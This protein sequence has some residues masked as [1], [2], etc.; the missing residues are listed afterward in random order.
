MANEFAPNGPAS[1]QREIAALEKRIAALR[2]RLGTVIDKRATVAA[3]FERAINELRGTR[4]ANSVAFAEVVLMVRRWKEG[5]GGY[6]K[7]E[8]TIMLRRLYSTYV[9]LLR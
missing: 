8:I 1:I 6:T 4:A 7:G 3:D 9:W 5:R 2:A